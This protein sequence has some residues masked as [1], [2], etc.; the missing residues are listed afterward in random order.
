MSRGA[1]SDLA[2]GLCCR[3]CCHCW[4]DLMQHSPDLCS[5]GVPEKGSNKEGGQQ[6]RW[7]FKSFKK[8]WKVSPLAVSNSCGL[9]AFRG[10]LHD[11]DGKQ[12]KKIEAT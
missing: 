5:E 8:Q 6:N 10:E 2:F 7:L 4:P 1:K 12:G 11:N 9:W 3:Y